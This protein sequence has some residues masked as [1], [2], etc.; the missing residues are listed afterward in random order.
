MVENP[1]MHFYELAADNGIYQ[2]AF[3]Y[4]HD[5]AQEYQANNSGYDKQAAVHHGF[6][7]S[8]LHAGPLH[9]HAVKCIGGHQD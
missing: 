7:I 5:L 4:E 2:G 3:T 1:G 8:P 9:N 6:Y